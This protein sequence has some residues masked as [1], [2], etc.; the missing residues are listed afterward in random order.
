[1]LIILRLLLV[2]AMTLVSTVAA[3]ATT[4]ANTIS[5]T[6]G[7]I[8]V[9]QLLNLVFDG[10]IIT[11]T[12]WTACACNPL[13]NGIALRLRYS[14]TGALIQR[15]Q[16]KLALLRQ[17]PVRPGLTENPRAGYDL[18]PSHAPL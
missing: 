2:V 11:A 14:F 13:L 5:L 4:T 3:A 15:I 9:L 6:G 7:I 16:L 17:Y 12:V 18:I 10:N 8:T 1:M